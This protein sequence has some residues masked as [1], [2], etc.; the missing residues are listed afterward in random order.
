METM[1]GV[2]L[3][4]FRDPV[5]P[6]RSWLFGQPRVMADDMVL[7]QVAAVAVNLMRGPEDSSPGAVRGGM[8]AADELINRVM[9]SIGTWHTP[10]NR[11]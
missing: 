5:T 11:R 6:V 3:P 9:D 8:T 10:P 1:A 4:F 7:P 2:D